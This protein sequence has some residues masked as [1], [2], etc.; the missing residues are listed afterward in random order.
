MNSFMHIILLQYYCSGTQSLQVYS[1]GFIYIPHFLSKALSFVLR[2]PLSSS[3]ISLL[4]TGS[5]Q[6]TVIHLR[7]FDFDTLADCCPLL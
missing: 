1:F 3:S 5:I 6:L 7:D 2:E 4:Q